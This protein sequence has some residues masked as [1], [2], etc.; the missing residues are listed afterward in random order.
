VRLGRYR[1]GCRDAEEALRLGTPDARLLYR[2]ARTFAQAAQQARADGALPAPRARA[3]GAEYQERALVLL[4]QALAA[5]PP[6]Q[7]AP[8]WS[9]TVRR[10]AALGPIRP[11]LAFDRL[12]RAY[13]SAQHAP[14]GP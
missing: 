4:R 7:R 1:E 13:S 14:E 11:A 12:E 3:L 9:K 2:A 10:D 8:F 6:E 5:L